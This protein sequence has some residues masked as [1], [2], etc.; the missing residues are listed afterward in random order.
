MPLLPD[1]LH[2]PRSTTTTSEPYRPLSALILTCLRTLIAVTWASVHPNVPAPDQS[3]LQ[4]MLHKVGMMV[5]ALVAPELMVFFAA[6]QLFVARKFASDYGVSITHGFFFSMGGFVDRT[7]GAPITTLAQIAPPLM[8]STDVDDAVPID[9]K[10][11][12]T[13]M[14]ATDTLPLIP[15]I[16]LRDEPELACLTEIPATPVIPTPIPDYAVPVDEEPE[17]IYL[18][19][20]RATPVED[21]RDKSKADEIVKGIALSHTVWF[22]VQIGVRVVRGL[23]ISELE[24]STLA[25]AVVNV[26]LWLLWWDKPQSVRQA[27]RI[28]PPT[29]P[30]DVSTEGTG[31]ERAAQR[32]SFHSFSE[33]F[34]RGPVQ[35]AYKDY[36]P[37]PRRSVP[38]F[39][40]HAT[41]DFDSPSSHTHA[42][43]LAQFSSFTGMFVG[44][45]FGALHLLA[46]SSPFPSAIERILWRVFSLLITVYPVFLALLHFLIG[47][48]AENVHHHVPRPVQIGGVA[49]YVVARLA[50]AVLAGTTLREVDAGWLTGV[51]WERFL[52]GIL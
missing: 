8:T 27:I 16:T 44:T 17:S 5:V 10:A 34:F 48:S 40:S 52:G 23:D 19:D 13:N 30:S 38:V 12:P 45:L 31:T 39:W 43:S 35:G 11:N 9:E 7:T 1:P 21:I 14:K 37:R 6:R 26:F 50:L 49:L 28:G 3:K 33:T 41:G 25:F 42:Q 2:L 18:T 29:P 4:N 36:K 22:I 24:V 15:H 32:Q 46:W 47:G 20:I 51:G